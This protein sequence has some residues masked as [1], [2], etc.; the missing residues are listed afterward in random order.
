LRTDKPYALDD[1][2]KLALRADLPF[3]ASNV[4]SSSNPAG[5][6][7][8]GLGDAL[9]QVLLI[10]TLDKR[11]AFGFGTQVIMPT[12][13]SD[14]FG[15]QSTRLIP[16]AG[17][18]YSLPEI[19]PGSFFLVAARYDFD[20]EGP[21]TRKPVSNYQ[22]SPSFN[23]ALPDAMFVTFYPS[24]DI[25]FNV[26]TQSWFVPFDVQVGKLWNKTIVTSL[27]Y[28]VPLYRRPAP[29]YNYKIEARVGIF[30]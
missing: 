6:Y 7:G 22:F 20:V 11:Q 16:T 8:V 21:A 29:L 26:I 12:A 5:A 30:F 23:V 1:G 27:E 3:T 13:S 14:Q 18:R 15:N 28:A 10:K 17:Y 2:W 4:P 19:S 9:A 25:R 24:Y